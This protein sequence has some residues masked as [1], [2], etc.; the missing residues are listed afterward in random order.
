MDIGT[1][2]EETITV[3]PIV[4]P[5]EPPDPAPAPERE[6]EPVPADAART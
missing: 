1:E 5:I 3:E 2:E 6:P 4:D